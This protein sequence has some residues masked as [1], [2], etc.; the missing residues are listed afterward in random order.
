MKKLIIVLSCVL[1]GLCSYYIIGTIIHAQ[2][3]LYNLKKH[4]PYY[5]EYEAETL[6]VARKIYVTLYN[7]CLVQK[8][9]R[10]YAGTA[11]LDGLFYAEAGEFPGGIQLPQGSKVELVSLFRGYEPS[12][13]QVGYDEYYY[14]K[15]KRIGENEEFYMNINPHEYS[16]VWMFFNENTPDRLVSSRLKD[17][18]TGQKAIFRIPQVLLSK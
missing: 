4:P 9:K 3:V 5:E 11:N 1:G 13:H 2:V 16:Y 6:G 7:A 18:E 12:S 14:A 8:G 15:F 17:I 10:Y